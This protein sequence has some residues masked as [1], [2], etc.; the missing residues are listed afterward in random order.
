MKKRQRNNE[1]VAL[2][3]VLILAVFVAVI[4]G[5]MASRTVQDNTHTINYVA[6]I[7]ATEASTA[8]LELGSDQVFGAF[9]GG[10]YLEFSEF[11]V[12]STGL[13]PGQSFEPPDLDLPIQL[14]GG[15]TIESVTVTRSANGQDFLIESTGT[16]GG[17]SITAVSGGRVGGEPFQGFGYAVLANNINCI[18]CHAWFDNVDRVNNTDSD[19]YGT[20]DR[21]K[22]ASLESLLVRVGSADSNLAGT[23][24]TRGVITDKSGNPL[25]DLEDSDV[26][27]R[28]F[29]A[30]GK[31]IEDSFGNMTPHELALTGT[32]AQTGLYDSNG[33]L[34]TDY[35]VCLSESHYLHSRRCRAKP[36]L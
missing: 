1:G 31:L 2:I 36:S 8:G 19:N 23:Y 34:Y 4:V 30:D 9:P 14:G 32:D 11:L 24:Y 13:E 18:M 12:D 5:V 28:E 6:A 7:R 25:S 22:I 35:P 20:Y 17:V 33:Y 16:S 21:I 3:S 27:G 15:A 26:T 29:D 10:T